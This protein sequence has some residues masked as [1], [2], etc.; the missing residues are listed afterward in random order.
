MQGIPCLDDVMLHVTY[1]KY[2]KS[3][4]RAWPPCG[5]SCPGSGGGGT[6]DLAGDGLD[7]GS[8]GG[9]VA[10]RVGW[11]SMDRVGCS[12]HKKA[13]EPWFCWLSGL[14]CIALGVQLVEVASLELTPNHLILNVEKSEAEWLAPR[15][16]PEIFVPGVQSRKRA[17]WVRSISSWATSG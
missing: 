6:A 1:W 12:G 9:A 13:R 16:A 2:W 4:R 17:I 11:I 15:L 3:R 14:S 10:P 7:G 8:L 5:S